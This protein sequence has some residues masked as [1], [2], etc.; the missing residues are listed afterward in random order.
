[1]DALIDLVALKSN[2]EVGKMCK[3]EVRGMEQKEAAGLRFFVGIDEY[4]WWPRECER[5][6]KMEM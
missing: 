1:V 6:G 4:R 3:D 5:R 2:K